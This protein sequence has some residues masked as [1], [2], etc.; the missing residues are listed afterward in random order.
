MHL[1]HYIL[2][3]IIC[4]SLWYGIIDFSL[5][6]MLQ[7]VR[8]LRDRIEREFRKQQ[9]EDGNV[10]E[11]GSQ[12][13]RLVQRKRSVSRSRQPPIRQNSTTRILESGDVDEVVVN[14]KPIAV[15]TQTSSLAL[16][17]DKV[18]SLLSNSESTLTSNTVSTSTQKQEEEE[19]EKAVAIVPK[20]NET[21]VI[22]TQQIQQIQQDQQPEPTNP[23]AKTSTTPPEYAT[24]ISTITKEFFTLLSPTSDPQWTQVATGTNPHLKVYQHVD[25]NFRVKVIAYLHTTPESAFDLLGNV[26]RR[27]EWDDMTTHAEV[28]EQLSPCTRIQRVQTKGIWP[29]GPREVVVVS[30]SFLN[31][32]NEYVIVTKSTTHPKA[33]VRDAEG[34]IRMEA[35]IAAQLVRKVPEHMMSVLGP[36]AENWCEIIQVADGDPKGW[37]PS[38]VMKFVSATALPASMR[39]L[40]ELLKRLPKRTTSEIMLARGVVLNRSVIIN[41]NEGDDEDEEIITKETMKE[42]SIVATSNGQEQRLFRSSSSITQEHHHHNHNHKHQTLSS[43]STQ[44]SQPNL[45]ITDTDDHDYDQDIDATKALG[46]PIPFLP[47]IRDMWIKLSNVFAIY[48]DSQSSSSSSSS[49]NNPLHRHRRPV[50]PPFGI[51]GVRFGTWSPWVVAIVVVATISYRKKFIKS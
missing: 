16:V 29:V 37:I 3:Q 22:P 49:T 31:E 43:T 46:I 24:T 39:R 4:I 23:T 26:A 10:V 15:Q 20:Q 8:Y 47:I 11:E 14:T 19:E 25:S 41:D 45:T 34:V 6:K 28:I 9:R 5:V 2:F 30:H 13:I 27:M 1:F 40:N 32:K 35:K 36:D 44:T 21:A 18:S 51:L 50:R 33:P 7:R 42:M 12:Q 17:W 48:P 38:S